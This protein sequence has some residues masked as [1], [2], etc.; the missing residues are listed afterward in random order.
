V[1]VL[2]NVQIPPALS[3]ETRFEKM[4]QMV[5]TCFRKDSGMC[6]SS[7]R[8][9]DIYVYNTAFLNLEQACGVRE[10]LGNALRIK[11]ERTLKSF[12]TNLSGL[13]CKI[14]TGL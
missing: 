9:N 1:G 5:I 4:P 12:T 8:M 3:L 6:S 7:N 13:P 11:T 10:V 14:H 2:T